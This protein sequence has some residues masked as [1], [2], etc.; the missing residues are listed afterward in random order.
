VY[1]FNSSDLVTWERTKTD[2][3]WS[4]PNIDIA[5]VYPSKEHP[6]PPNLP[7]HRYVMASEKRV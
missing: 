2:V 3:A 6:T 5:R 4:G 7:K 1:V